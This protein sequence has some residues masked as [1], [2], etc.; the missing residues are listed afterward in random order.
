MKVSIQPQFS[1]Y[2]NLSKSVVAIY[3]AAIYLD[4]D[5]VYRLI[6]VSWFFN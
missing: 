2:L 1:I 4:D 5:K 6:K 3:L